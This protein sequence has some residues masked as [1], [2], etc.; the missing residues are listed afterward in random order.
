L[1]Y[2]LIMIYSM[3]IILSLN[4][5]KNDSKSIWLKINIYIDKSKYSFKIS[6]FV[7]FV[8]I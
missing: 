1:I 4:F 7:I 5:L 6:L 2:K 8:I 3:F